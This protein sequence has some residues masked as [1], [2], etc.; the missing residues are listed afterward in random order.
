MMNSD[1]HC[2]M[3]CEMVNAQDMLMAERIRSILF[4]EHQANAVE[5]SLKLD[6]NSFSSG[7][8]PASSWSSSVWIYILCAVALC[9]TVAAGLTKQSSFPYRNPQDLLQQIS[10]WTNSAGSEWGA[11]TKNALKTI[12][13]VDAEREL[14]VNTSSSSTAAGNRRTATNS[15]GSNSAE[16][17]LLK[18]FQDLGTPSFITTKY[19]KSL[20]DDHVTS[21][22]R[23]HNFDDADWRRYGLK[24]SHIAVLRKKL[25]SM[26]NEQERADGKGKSKDTEDMLDDDDDDDDD[27][28]L[29]FD[30]DDEWNAGGATK[31]KTGDNNDDDNGQHTESTTDFDDF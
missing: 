31:S 24:Q 14:T 3:L 25:N 11:D 28:E 17:F 9:G 5:V 1:S 21:I 8:V 27:D 15:S 6:A 26:E 18:T 10:K 13:S 7:S 29:S 22:E 12:E 19:I 4:S 20:R 2:L 16:Q 30:D 23:L